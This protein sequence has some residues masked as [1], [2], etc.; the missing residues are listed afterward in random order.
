MNVQGL[1]RGGLGSRS[2]RPKLSKHLLI[3]SR[4][5]SD[6]F[7]QSAA[8]TIRRHKEFKARWPE[9]DESYLSD[10]E[11][12]ADHPMRASDQQRLSKLYDAE[13]REEEF[14]RIRHKF[15]IPASTRPQQIAQENPYVFSASFE[16]RNAVRERQPVVALESTIYTHGFPYPE[17]VALAL[18]IER[19]VRENGAIPATIGVLDG[20]ARIG[21]N[22]EEITRLAACAGKEETMKVSR[23]DLP[24]ILGM[25]CR[26]FLRRD[27]WE[28]EKGC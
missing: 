22:S 1:W 3:S 12:F 5:K 2:T 10:P 9:L 20:V 26:Y 16:V 11:C 24:F 13:L 28:I 19:I 7:D 15:G 25:V 4:F 6:L 17:N 21:M 27:L 14:G 23:R 18:D 8:A